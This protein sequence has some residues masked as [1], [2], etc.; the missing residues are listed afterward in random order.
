MNRAALF[1]I[2][3]CVLA[4]SCRVK[5]AEPWTTENK[6]VAATAVTLTV[7]D[8]GQ[9]R[10][11]AKNPDKF[12]GVNP[13]LVEHPSTREVDRYFAGAIAL[14]LI[15]GHNLSAK[16]RTR[17]FGGAAFLEAGV[18]FNNSMIGVKVDF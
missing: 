7:I 3:M 12:K 10:Y 13:I 14:E 15:I 5:A 4:Y 8:W 1:L 17:F 2:L 9:N 18:V 16:W 11:A 6:W